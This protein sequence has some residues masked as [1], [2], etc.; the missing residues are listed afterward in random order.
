MVLGKLG[1]YLPKMETRFLSSNLQMTTQN[2]A[3]FSN[4]CV[5]T[6]PYTATDKDL[7]SD[8]SSSESHCNT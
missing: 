5:E 7:L 3:K 2:E 6:L 4:Y 1:V 8:C